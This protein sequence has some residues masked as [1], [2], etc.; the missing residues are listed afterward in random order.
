MLEVNQLTIARPDLLGPFRSSLLD[1]ADKVAVAVLFKGWKVLLVL[2]LIP[3]HFWIVVVKV[4]E[5]G[6]F[7]VDV[8][9]DSSLALFLHLKSAAQAHQLVFRLFVPILGLRFFRLIRIVLAVFAGAWEFLYWSKLSA[10]RLREFAAARV[11]S[12]ELLLAEDVLQSG[13]GSFL[14]LAETV[15][16]VLQAVRLDGLLADPGAELA[17]H[18]VKLSAGTDLRRTLA[19]KGRAHAHLRR[20]ELGDARNRVVWWFNCR[21]PYH[22]LRLHRVYDFRVWL[23]HRKRFFKLD[24]FLAGT[25][26]ELLCE[27]LLVF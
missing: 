18:L 5:I 20:T 13:V 3:R 10:R 24:G 11:V 26:T 22:P 23:Q 14:I 8:V 2:L 19:T 9:L 7:V 17:Q 12:L 16:G 21:L 6:G 1:W 4:F 15:S 25:A 27:S